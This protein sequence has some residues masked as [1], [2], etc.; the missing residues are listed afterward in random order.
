MPASLKCA[1]INDMNLNKSKSSLVTELQ[2][3]WIKS[4]QSLLESSKQLLE[5]TSKDP[6][7][8]D[9]DGDPYTNKHYVNIVLF[10]LA[11][12]LLEQIKLRK[13]RSVNTWLKSYDDLYRKSY[14][15][16]AYKIDDDNPPEVFARTKN[17]MEYHLEIKEALDW[18]KS[19]RNEYQSI[20]YAPYSIRGKKNDD[21]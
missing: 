11:K 17:D 15:G 9:L 21:D 4:A 6:Q 7:E 14:I 12:H 3:S 5:I 10:T 16:F 8:I 20:I 13:Y 2:E 18:L 19:H 1:N